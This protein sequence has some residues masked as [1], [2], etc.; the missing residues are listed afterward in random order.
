M[1]HRSSWLC[2]AAN[3]FLN[4]SAGVPECDIWAEEKWWSLT[5]DFA[6][7]SSFSPT[8]V[9]VEEVSQIT[10]AGGK[11]MRHW[12]AHLKASACS[13]WAFISIAPSSWASMPLCHFLPFSS[14]LSS[15][16]F[17]NSNLFQAYCPMNWQ[18][19]LNNL[20]SQPI[21]VST[22]KPPSEVRPF[23]VALSSVSLACSSSEP[24]P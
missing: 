16:V 7:E 12:N 11:W 9:C 19:T 13:Y 24:L 23:H 4:G 8:L 10:G 22:F 17:H 18:G 6:L 3:R 20:L 1:G 2:Y 5:D 21:P 14:L 15:M